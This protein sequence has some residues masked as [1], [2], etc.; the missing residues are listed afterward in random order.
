MRGSACSVIFSFICMK[1]H[2]V[3]L[4]LIYIKSRMTTHKYKRFAQKNYDKRFLLK[5][6]IFLSENLV[7]MT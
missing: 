4:G 5:F 3:S 7:L 1:S 6:C 2:N